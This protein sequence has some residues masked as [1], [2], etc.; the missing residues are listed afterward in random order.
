[1]ANALAG[2]GQELGKCQPDRHAACQK[3][4]V[5]L[6]RQG[7][8]QTIGGWDWHGRWH[9]VSPGRGTPGMRHSESWQD[10]PDVVC[11]P[12]VSGFPWIIR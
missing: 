8:K 11:G 9:M 7:C 6:A 3:S 2:L 5:V 10:T 12:R 4:L 1:M